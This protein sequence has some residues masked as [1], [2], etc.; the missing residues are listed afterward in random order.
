MENKKPQ[1]RFNGFDEDWEE[2]DFDAVFNSISNNTLS[3][4]M[5]NYYSGNAKNIHYGDVLVK[6]NEIVDVEKEVIPFISDNCQV[7]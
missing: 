2:S 5:L 7:S 3:R 4:E 6:F 1:V